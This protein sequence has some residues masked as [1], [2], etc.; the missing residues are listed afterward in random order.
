MAQIPIHSYE[1]LRKKADEFLLG[2]CMGIDY[3][4]FGES[5]SS[6]IKCDRKKAG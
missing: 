4:A 3:R 6:V 1:D 2:F 5:L